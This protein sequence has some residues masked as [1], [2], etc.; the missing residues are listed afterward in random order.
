[1]CCEER[2]AVIKRAGRVMLHPLA[3]IGVG[4]L[5]PIVVSRRQLVMD[6]LRNGKRRN[7]E[8]K[9]DKADCHS[10]PKNPGQT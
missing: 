8:Q 6:I 3:E 5:V 4:V 10:A 7:G 2:S 9:E 1:M